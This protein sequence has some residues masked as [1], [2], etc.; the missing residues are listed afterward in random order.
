[1]LLVPVPLL[2]LTLYLGKFQP[3]FLVKNV[4][5][6]KEYACLCPLSGNLED[7]LLM[8]RKHHPFT[9]KFSPVV[10]D[11][12]KGSG[13]GSYLFIADPGEAG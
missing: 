12:V 7:V 13:D 10:Q 5:G 4:L 8:L 3:I 1:L 2:S 11:G 9:E 6:K